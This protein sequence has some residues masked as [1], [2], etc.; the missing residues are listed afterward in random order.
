MNFVFHV[1]RGGKKKALKRRRD[2]TPVYWDKYFEQMH[3]VKVGENVS[4]S[5]IILFFDCFAC[6][7]FNISTVLFLI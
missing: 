1:L 5:V 2:Y 6:V 7:V 4:F 3:D